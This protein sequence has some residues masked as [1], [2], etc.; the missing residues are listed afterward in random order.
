MKIATWNVNSIRT[1]LDHVLRWIDEHKPDVLCL[2]ET[3]AQD[4]DFPMAAFKDSGLHAAFAGQKSYNGVAIISS[5]PI[6]EVAVGFPHLDP[7]HSFNVQ[8][9][10]ISAT[11]LG[12]RVASAYF[13]N[14][15]SPESEKFPYKL[16]FM[17]ELKRHFELTNSLT[18][19]L[20]LMG[21]F[22]VAPEDRDVYDPQAWEGRILCS[23]PERRAL[24][25]LKSFGF[26]DC[27]RKHRAEGGLYSWWDYR[28]G[29]FRRDRGLR[30]DHI[31]ATPPLAHWCVD[32]GVDKA[33]RSWEK[34]SD[35]APVWACFNRGV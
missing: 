25:D 23:E 6:C 33:P 5:S 27:F 9:R 7:E 32:S 19:P 10:L 13:P 14:G 21:D 2:Q 30:I 18:K 15:E 12:V 29:A 1:R 20:C 4:K 11:V 35:H 3:K 16:G 28:M 22:N 31:W 8:K 24:E 17:G 26:V 34:P